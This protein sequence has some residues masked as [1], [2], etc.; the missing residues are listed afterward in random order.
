MAMNNSVVRRNI[1]F[2]TNLKR[3]MINDPELKA[4]SEVY[5]ALRGLDADTQRRVTEWVLGKLKSG[6]SSTGSKRGPKAG[7]KRGRKPGRPAAA[8]ST[9]ARRGRKPGKKR[10]RPAGT[11]AVKKTGKRG[12]PSGTGKKNSTAK[13]GRGRPRKV[14]AAPAA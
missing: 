10:G 2:F 4:M 5:D 11:T 14:V 1:Y 13:R 9:G 6:S 12:R 8:K 7:K 3:I